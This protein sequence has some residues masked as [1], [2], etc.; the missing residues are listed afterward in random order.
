MKRRKDGKSNELRH[1]NRDSSLRRNS[2]RHLLPFYRHIRRE[3][4]EVMTLGWSAVHQTE[5]R[6]TEGA[7]LLIDIPCPAQTTH[8][9]VAELAN[10]LKPFP[11]SN[12]PRFTPDGALTPPALRHCRRSD[13][14]LCSSGFPIRHRAFST[15][16]FS[17]VADKKLQRSGLRVGQIW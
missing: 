9:A 10:A 8:H 3:A 12:R 1:V 11:R 7:G 17:V 15:A 2:R 6:Q 13:P 5:R 16:G 14:E 4:G